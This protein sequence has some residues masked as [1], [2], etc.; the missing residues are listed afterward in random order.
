M[1]KLLLLIISISLIFLVGCSN[2]F[3]AAEITDIWWHNSGNMI[4]GNNTLDLQVE[5]KNSATTSIYA[6]FSIDDNTCILFD[7]GFNYLKPSIISPKQTQKYN[8]TIQK[9][10]ECCGPQPF[11]LSYNDVAR[12]KIDSKEMY[13]SIRCE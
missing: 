4:I 11:K 1:K 8:I 12:Y 5:I 3:K 6:F 13:L 9:K 2:H 7:N 10:K